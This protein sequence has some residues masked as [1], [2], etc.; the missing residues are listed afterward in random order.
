[1][2]RELSDYQLADVIVIPSQHV[3]RSFLER[4]VPSERLF[5]NP[6]GVDLK[7]FHPTPAPSP[8]PPTV[9]MT[10][11]WSLRKGCD[12]LVEAWRRLRGVR[13]MHVGPVE[14]CRLPEDGNFE[15]HRP[16]RASRL[17]DFYAQ[18]H[19]FALASREEGLALV[20]AQALACGLP[21]VCTDRT[22]GEDLKAFVDDP[23]LIRVVPPDDPRALAEGLQEALDRARRA[24]G[25]RDLL[26]RGRER[27]SWPAYA[28][29]Y[30]R[31]LRER[32]GQ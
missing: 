3:E 17:K 22:G 18:G 21:L 7:E 10:G 26:G 20:Q 23:A 1:L 5:R 19:V 16:V 29:R 12:V 32:V 6:Y 9:L 30:D 24:A 14:D 4:G 8:D 15:H 11:T 27:L 2:W 25:P 13:L 31:F 28:E